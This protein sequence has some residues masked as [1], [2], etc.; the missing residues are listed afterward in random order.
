MRGVYFRLYA[1]KWERNIRAGIDGYHAARFSMTLRTEG[2][3]INVPQSGE[4]GICKVKSFSLRGGGVTEKRLGNTALDWYMINSIF[5]MYWIK[6][7][8]GRNNSIWFLIQNKIKK[9]V[10]NIFNF[11]VISNVLNSL[12]KY[13]NSINRLW[14]HEN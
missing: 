14:M 5:K 2:R 3:V 8:F 12:F 7:C 10:V 6:A 9:L 11:L 1:R 13:P 4:F